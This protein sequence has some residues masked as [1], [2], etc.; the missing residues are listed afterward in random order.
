MKK[1]YYLSSIV[2]SV[3]LLV[4]TGVGIFLFYNKDA[5]VALF[6][7]SSPTIEAFSPEKISLER[8]FSEDKSYISTFSADHLRV[9]NVTGDVI[10][11]RTVNSRSQLYNSYTWA[12]EKTAPRVKDADLT[13]INL[14]TPL[15]KACTVTDV[16]MI[17]CGSDAHI[18]G[19]LSAGVDVANL[20][21]NHA[22]NHGKEGVEETTQLLTANGIDFTGVPGKIAVRE[23]R[24]KKFAFLGYTDIEP[25]PWVSRADEKIIQDEVG[26]AREIADIV[27]VQFHWGSEYQSLP[28]QRQRDLGKLA[29]DS[30]ADL[31]I[32]NHPHWIQP[33]ELY[34]NRLITYAHG[35]Y[36]FDQMWSQK[37][38]EGVLGRYYFYDNTLIDVEYIPLEI[39][40]FGQAQWITD[41]Q[42]RK[43]ILDEMKKNSEKLMNEPN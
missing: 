40:D 12:F 13:F 37:T 27:I 42:H 38:R 29:V 9:L 4:I 10:P 8:I 14:E 15:L 32:G 2:F 16:G 30:G 23:V 39:S 20:G 35:N 19:L 36:I 6:T 21:N 34:K 28:D 3:L 18:V 22:G 17:F 41:D 11:A 33:I 24:G 31:V 5:Q 26:K 1:K 7:P 43:Q 25:V